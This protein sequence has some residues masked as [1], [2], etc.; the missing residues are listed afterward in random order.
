M[1]RAK[2]PYFSSP[3]A[4]AT[5]PNRLQHCSDSTGLAA[6]MGRNATKTTTSSCEAIYEIAITAVTR[7][8]VQS[9][10]APLNLNP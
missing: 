4:R 5:A 10:H 8:S 9:P 7:G 2:Q 1:D 6:A 3:S